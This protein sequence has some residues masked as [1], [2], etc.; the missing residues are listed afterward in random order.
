LVGAREQR[1]R[2]IQAKRLGSLE[3]ENQL[4]F[5]GLLLEGLPAFR[6]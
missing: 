6:L 2:H 3:I 5:G 4:D 1:P